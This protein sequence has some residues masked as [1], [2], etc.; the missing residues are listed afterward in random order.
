MRHQLEGSAPTTHL[1]RR[2]SEV[3]KMSESDVP[4]ATGRPEM[5]SKHARLACP[6]SSRVCLSRCLSLVPLL[7][8]RLAKLPSR[9]SAVL[10]PP[11]TTTTST[12]STT[13]KVTCEYLRQSR[14]W[15]IEHDKANRRQQ[16]QFHTDTA[17]CTFIPTRRCGTLL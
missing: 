13:T 12:T 4:D 6:A 14:T 17:L 8:S 16:H 7:W 5:K 2:V 3:V 11:P 15:T 1:Y 10:H 9:A